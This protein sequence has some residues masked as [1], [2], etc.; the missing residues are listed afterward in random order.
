M[1][2]AIASS[3][4]TVTML[5][6]LLRFACD[7]AAAKEQPERDVAVSDFEKKLFP[8]KSLFMSLKLVIWIAQA[9]KDFAKAP[10]TELL[11]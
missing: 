4:P 7:V 10:V 9:N 1:R 3:L 2:Q 8:M 6:S 11:K 5:V